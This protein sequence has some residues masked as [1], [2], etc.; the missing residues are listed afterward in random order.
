MNP[1]IRYKIERKSNGQF[2]WHRKAGNGKIHSTGHEFFLRL[3]GAVR[4][5]FRDCGAKR[6]ADKVSGIGLAL[7]DGQQPTLDSPLGTVTVH[8]MK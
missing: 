5:I 2:W 8:F 6:T 1:K 4:A 7:V 3:Q